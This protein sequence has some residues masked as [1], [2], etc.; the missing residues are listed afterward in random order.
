MNRLFP[1]AYMHIFTACKDEHFILR[2][3]SVADR[4]YLG[5]CHHC[6]QTGNTQNG[7]AKSWA[8]FD[9]ALQELFRLTF[10]CDCGNENCDKQI[11]LHEA[12]QNFIKDAAGKYIWII[13]SDEPEMENEE[14][15]QQILDL[16]DAG[17][18]YDTAKKIVSEQYNKIIIGSHEINNVKLN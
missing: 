6:K 9:A 4:I 1:F 3:T 15:T 7:F 16:I 8:R 5:Y 12:C 18:N 10:T 2:D 14:Y 13:G 17:V 11:A